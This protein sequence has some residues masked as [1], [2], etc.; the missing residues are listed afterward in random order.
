MPT[1]RQRLASYREFHASI[2][3]TCEPRLSISDA[4]AVELVAEMPSTSFRHADI[5]SAALALAAHLQ[6]AVPAGDSSDSMIEWA[7]E[8]KRRVDALWSALAG[9]TVD[10]VVI[11]RRTA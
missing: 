4:E 10:G 3:S 5:P 1:M 11:L 6:A 2:P 8:R 9:E 7:Q